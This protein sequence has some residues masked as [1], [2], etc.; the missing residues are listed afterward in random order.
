MSLSAKLDR[1]KIG[2]VVDVQNDFMIPTERG[3]RLYVHD[4]FNPADPGATEAAPAIEQAV[5]WMLDHCDVLVYTGDWHSLEDE[6]IDPDHPDP[7]KGTYPPHC[8]GLSQDPDER[9]GALVLESIRPEDPHLLRRG[10]DPEEAAGVARA[11]LADGR[12]IFIHKNK[13]DVFQ[14]NPAAERLVQVL[15]DELGGD[16]D[17]VVAG[18]AR[19]VCVTQAVD[20]L[21][22]RGYRTVAVRDATWG[23][24]LEPESETL[25]RWARG[26]RVVTLAELRAETAGVT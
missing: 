13:F 2:W 17:F 12:P 3:G 16:P 19:D 4:L 22:A 9:R 5:A 18:V 15:A 7:E 10:A 24:G 25:S 6:E 11:A 14:G 20:G 1:R 23:L 8:M 26:G 21:Q